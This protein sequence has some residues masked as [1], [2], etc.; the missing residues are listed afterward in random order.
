[1]KKSI[2]LLFVIALVTIRQLSYG[3]ATSVSQLCNDPQ[4]NQEFN[5]YWN[6]IKSDY[7]DYA[8][9]C[10][11]N[12]YHLYELQIESEPLLRYSFENQ[13]YNITDDLLNIYRSTLSKLTHT[14]KYQFYGY[15]DTNHPGYTT[16]TLDDYYDMWISGQDANNPAI[17]HVLA[18]S[19]FLA[20]ISYAVFQISKIAPT[21]R[22]QTMIDFVNDFIPVLASHYKRW[23]LGTHINNSTDLKGLF[24]RRAW[25]CKYNGTYV[26]TLLTHQQV[27]DKLIQDQF[28]N[29]NS[30]PYCNAVQDV[31]LWIIAGVTGLVGAYSQDSNLIGNIVN[32]QDFTNYVNTANVLLQDRTTETSLTDFN[33][34]PVT[35]AIFGKNDWDGF[36]NHDYAGYTGLTFP[37]S[38]DMA[39]LTG[40]GWDI[41]HGRRFISAFSLIYDAKDIIGQYSFPSSTQMTEFANQFAYQV[42]NKDFTYPAFNNYWSGINGW[43]R[44]KLNQGFGYQPSD[45]S[46]AALTG[47]YGEYAH[48]NPQVD[49]VMLAVYNL[50]RYPDTNQ[51]NFVIET[52][53]KNHWSSHTHQQ[54]YQFTFPVDNISNSSFRVRA[55]LVLVSFYSSMC[56]NNEST[57]AIQDKKEKIQTKIFPN[58]ADSF[59]RIE[60]VKPIDTEHIKIYNLQGKDVSKNVIVKS[61]DKNSAT[62]D[63]R[64]LKIGNYLLNVNN[65]SKIII[66]RNSLINQ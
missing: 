49:D 45:L 63:I 26:E 8:D 31:D 39:P 55:K 13:K 34:N 16:Q 19:Q 43:Y 35:G 65:Q 17:E 54:F 56:H 66:K 21:D 27:V 5:S 48:Y 25:G 52:Y 36:V 41:S 44:V 24:Q 15:P 60:S 10:G 53:E 12:A 64:K 38:A 40:T 33:N 62:I 32:L 7:Q 51:R 57:N 28:G 23:V 37:T 11:Q 59:I 4:F 18:S 6:D 46:D 58:P 14:N 47:M 30:E 20:M 22:T 50:I 61:L 29:G 3:Q 9:Y 2:Q 42:F 1:M